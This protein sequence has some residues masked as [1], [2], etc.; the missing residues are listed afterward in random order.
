[1]IAAMKRSSKLLPASPA[2]LIANLLT[3]SQCKGSAEA[4]TASEATGDSFTLAEA[5]EC[6]Q[7]D[8][9]KRAMEEEST[10]IL[11]DNTFSALNSQ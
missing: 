10:L 1:M 7:R 8:H 5:M 3:R 2:L 9:R 4:L 11:L 6:P